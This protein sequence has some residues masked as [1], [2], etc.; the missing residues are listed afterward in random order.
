MVKYSFL[1]RVF[2]G[3]NPFVPIFL[4]GKFKFLAVNSFLI[5]LL[6]CFIK[7]KKY[8]KDVLVKNFIGCLKT[9]ILVKLKLRY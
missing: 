6:I 5:V 3:S 4:F 1:K 7:I 2:K 8:K 9:K